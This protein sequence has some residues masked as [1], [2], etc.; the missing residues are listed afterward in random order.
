MRHFT[1]TNLLK[2]KFCRSLF[3]QRAGSLLLLILL[4][5]CD[6]GPVA[7]WKSVDQKMV[8]LAKAEMELE[9]LREKHE[10]LQK[11]YLRLEKEYNN[12]VTENATH[13]GETKRLESTGSMVGV[14]PKELNYRVPSG[15]KFEELT[16]LAEDHLKERRF[17]E[18]AACYES[19]FSQPEYAAL[20]NPKVYYSSG[21]A[22]YELNNFVKAR[23]LFDLAK[24]NAKGELKTIIW[25][26]VD[27]WFRVIDQKITHAKPLDDGKTLSI[28]QAPR[29]LA[30]VNDDAK[31]NHE[32]HTGAAKEAD[33]PEH[34]DQREQGG[35]Q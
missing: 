31:I 22:W 29:G 11:K 9:V 10:E 14:S 1:A 21:I 13:E 2:T 32:K 20:L 15:L 3:S 23:E 19:L 18:A 26:K 28:P 34:A 5:S 27:L 16:Q 24:A 17:A 30:S 12:L 7:W 6:R 4:T 35:H 8:H 33:H 25:K